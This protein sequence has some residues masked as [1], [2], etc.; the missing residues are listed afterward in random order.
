MCLVIEMTEKTMSIHHFSY[1]RTNEHAVKLSASWLK[2]E[3][4]FLCNTFACCNILQAQLW[5]FQGLKK[6]D[7]GQIHGGQAGGGYDTECLGYNAWLHK[8]PAANCPEAEGGYKWKEHLTLGQIFILFPLKTSLLASVRE[9][10]L[11]QQTSSHIHM[12]VYVHAW[13]QTCNMVL[14]K[15]DPSPG[16]AAGRGHPSPQLWKA[17][18]SSSAALHTSYTLPM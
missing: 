10:I 18:C 8:C 16:G 9:R 3:V 13:K 2:R 5:V 4:F 1:Q 15:G 17:A 7:F 14:S 11:G 6:K 12:D